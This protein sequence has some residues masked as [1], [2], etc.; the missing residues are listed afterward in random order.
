MRLRTPAAAMAAGPVLGAGQTE[1][2]FERLS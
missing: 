1:I 2:M